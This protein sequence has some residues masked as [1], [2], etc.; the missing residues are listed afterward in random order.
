LFR[1]DD[2]PVTLLF[3]ALPLYR[4]LRAGVT[5]HDVEQ[6][7]TNL[8]DLG[9]TGF[10]VDQE[11]TESTAA[12]VKKWQRSL[13][14]VQTG[15]IALGQLLFATGPVRVA[16]HR[17]LVGDVA[18]GDI[19]GTTGSARSITTSVS[20][21]RVRSPLDAGAPVT[22]LLPDGKEV[23]GTVRRTGTPA[24]GGDPQSLQVQV[25][26]ADQAALDAR[27]GTA[28]VRF[29]VADRKD[30]LA[31]PVLALV[32]LA[33]GG[34]GLQLPDGSYV[35]VGTGLFARGFVEITSGDVRE[36]TKVVIPRG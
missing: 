26:V 34:Y 16:E 15:E 13:G 36:G 19:L 7:E 9:Y 25:D 22:V 18:A 17:L 5:G 32:A 14:V 1:V 28:T 35:A 29:V 11:Y 3:G 21:V 10:S 2:Q 27:Q 24:V 31:V 6:F 8:R 23:A 12:A 30:V 33:E 4:A 20:K